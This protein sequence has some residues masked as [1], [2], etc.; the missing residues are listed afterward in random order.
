[1][2]VQFFTI[3][4]LCLMYQDSMKVSWKNTDF[5]L[6]RKNIC[7]CIIYLELIYVFKIY[8]KSINQYM[9]YFR[10]YLECNNFIYKNV[11]INVSN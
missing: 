3:E 1:M 6:F 7:I 4:G 5:E 2:V 11:C 9:I 8:E 10:M